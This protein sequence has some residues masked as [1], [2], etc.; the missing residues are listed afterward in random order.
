MWAS[1]YYYVCLE[2]FEDS[3]E[4]GWPGQGL[5][6]AYRRQFALTAEPQVSDICSAFELEIPRWET[7]MTYR[8]WG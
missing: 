7:G 5:M 8:T 6:G 2:L 3:V 4:W 1:L